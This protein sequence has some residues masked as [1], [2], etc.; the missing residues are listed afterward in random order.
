MQPSFLVKVKNDGKPLAGVNVDVS[1][2][3]GRSK[4]FSGTTRPDGTV[5]VSKLPIGDYWL[6]VQYLGV[7]AAYRC[8]HVES[9]PTRKAKKQLMLSWGDYAAGTRQVAGRVVDFQP[10]EGG[11]PLWNMIHGRE[12]PIRGASMKLTTPVRGISYTAVSDD[13]GDF[14]FSTVPKGKYVLHI[15][16][17]IVK[18]GRTYG[19]ADFLVEL[20]AQ[21]QYDTL[22]LTN[23]D[24]AAGNCRG[25]ISLDLRRS[26]N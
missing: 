23:R 11:T 13:K 25:G 9:H 21:A 2:Q 16:G 15:D 12:V 10:G 26:G 6:S 24:A 1:T 14:A 7:G 3:D 8:F 4:Q 19:A 17:G 18:R 22:L 20:S 5:P